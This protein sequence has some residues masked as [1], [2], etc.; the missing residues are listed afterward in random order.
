MT[1]EKLRQLLTNGEV[2]L[3][4]ALSLVIK[5]RLDAIQKA[6]DAEPKSFSWKMRAK[7]GTRLRWYEE[8]EEVQR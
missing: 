5:E 2:A 6:M 8:V 1:I 4:E 7:V 3:E